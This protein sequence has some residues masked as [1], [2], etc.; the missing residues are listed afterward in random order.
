M[1]HKNELIAS[2]RTAYDRWEDL[3]GGMSEEGITRPRFKDDWS[4]QDFVTHLWAWQQISVAR[5]E[6]ALLD[7]PPT[8][9]AWLAGTDPFIA[10]DHTDEFN[11]RIR[12]ENL[13]RA[14]ADVHHDWSAGFRRLI[15][16]AEQ[17]PEDVMFEERRYSWLKGYPLSGV[18]SGSL[19]H[20]QEHL[21]GI[22]SALTKEST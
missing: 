9:P 7:K 8:Y 5:F 18:L 1:A 6:A 22:S 11:A 13:D 20:H 2:L 14:W 15:D 17:T 19:E 21:E 3:L 12:A 10:E 16:L 4:V